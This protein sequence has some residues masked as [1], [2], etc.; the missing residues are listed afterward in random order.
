MPKPCLSVG[1]P[2]RTKLEITPPVCSPGQPTNPGWPSCFSSSVIECEMLREAACD[3]QHCS[4]T[5]L[6]T[7]I[8]N[9]PKTIVIDFSRSL[10]P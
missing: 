6:R 7:N 3:K 1:R 4:L 10:R 8:E 2:P 5:A 9:T